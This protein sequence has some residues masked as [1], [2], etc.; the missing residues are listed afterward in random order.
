MEP[1]NRFQGT[2]S[3]SLCSL[4]GRY[5]NSVPNSHRLFKNSSTVEGKR[6]SEIPGIGNPF[7]HPGDSGMEGLENTGDKE[8]G[9]G[10]EMWDWRTQGTK[11]QAG[12]RYEGW[13]DW[14]KRGTKTSGGG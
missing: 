8:T 9:K 7:P 5:D 2:D 10:A 6:K 3:A 13:R 11:E 4:T 14:R 1:K 12:V